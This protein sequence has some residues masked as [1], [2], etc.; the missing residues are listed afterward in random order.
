MRLRFS[1]QGVLFAVRRVFPQPVL[2]VDAP[3]SYRDYFFRRLFSAT[4]SSSESDAPL[5]ECGKTRFCSCFW[6]AQRFTAA[7][8]GLS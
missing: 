2:A 4:A 7:I 8:T 1:A 3:P 6:V 5:A